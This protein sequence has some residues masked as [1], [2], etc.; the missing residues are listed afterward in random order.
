[1]I[2]VAGRVEVAVFLGTGHRLST[3]M[4]IDTSAVPT[5]LSTLSKMASMAHVV[6]RV[7]M[8]STPP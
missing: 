2:P 5:L 3:I 8:R 4:R 6:E 7:F 1:M